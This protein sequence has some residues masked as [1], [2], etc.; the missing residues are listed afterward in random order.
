M[1][2]E[3]LRHQGNERQ[4]D[5]RN[6]REPPVHPDE[7][8]HDADEREDI[9]ED[10]HYAGGEQIVDDVHVGRHPGHQ[11][12]HGVSV[13]VLEVQALQVRVDRHPQVEHDALARE[14]QREGLD[15]LG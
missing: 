6:E 14:L 3:P 5:E 13:E 12:A 15:V 1:L 8:D 7:D 10:R 2:P 9:A 4:H 11:P